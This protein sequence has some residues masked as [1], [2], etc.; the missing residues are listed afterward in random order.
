MTT[1]T[2]V[3]KGPYHE[4]Q[5]VLVYTITRGE[6]AEWRVPILRAEDHEILVRVG[7]KALAFQQHELGQWTWR[8]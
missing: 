1:F 4:G 6:P 3:T 5:R 2:I 7:G 8:E